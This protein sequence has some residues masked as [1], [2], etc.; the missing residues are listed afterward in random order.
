MHTVKDRRGNDRPT[1]LR[2]ARRL[3]LLPSV[4]NV[5]GVIAKEQLVA[6][7]IEQAVLAAL[8]L[9]QTPDEP[10]DAFARRVVEDAKGKV[11][12]ASE[13][14]TLMHAGAQRVATNPLDVDGKDPM[15]PWLRF[16]RDWCL[17][18]VE[19]VLWCEHTTVN[20]DEGYAGTADA[21][22]VHRAWGL[23]LVD[24]KTQ[25]VK[26]GAEPRVYPSWRYQL[27]AYRRALRIDCVCMN[28]VVNATTPGPVMEHLWAAEDVS[29]GWEVF[30]AAH[31]IWRSEK[32]YDPRERRDEKA[33]CRMKNAECKVQNAECQKAER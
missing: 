13:F 24:I 19:R 22:F 27:A 14:G 32:E 21:L 23:C 20:N 8:T 6:W 33:E 2:D 1:T 11:S 26:T 28:L 7:K 9:P 17:E 3:D 30:R 15:A 31:T 25:G 12:Q 10:L 4:T 5:L 18:N 16:Y 29:Q